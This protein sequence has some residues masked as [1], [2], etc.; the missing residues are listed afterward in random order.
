MNEKQRDI[1]HLLV[2][3]KKK[4]RVRVFR[5]FCVECGSHDHDCMCNKYDPTNF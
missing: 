2:G 5:E 4:E 3:L 1:V